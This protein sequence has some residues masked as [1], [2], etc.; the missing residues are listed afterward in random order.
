MVAGEVRDTIYAAAPVP[1]SEWVVRTDQSK[2][3]AL[4]MARRMKRQHRLFL[5]SGFVLSIL[6]GW[7]IA[8]SVSKPIGS[9]SDA[10]Q[11]ISQGDFGELPQTKRGDEI[12]ELNLS[13]NRMVV[14]LQETLARLQAARDFSERIVENIPAGLIVL[15]KGMKVQ[16][17]NQA[18]L[19]I[20]G[21]ESSGDLI[22][23]SIAEMFGS[24]KE[25]MASIQDGLEGGLFPTQERRV[26][27]LD[28]R[29]I[30]AVVTGASLSGPGGE[31]E[32]LL[33]LIQDVTDQRR[34]ERQL[35]QSEKLASVGLISAGISHEL[36]NPLN[37]I[38]WAT[39][40][41]EEELREGNLEGIEG[42]TGSIK[43]AVRRCGVVINTLLDFTRPSPKGKEKVDINNLLDSVVSLTEEPIRTSRIEVWRNYGTIP[44]VEVNLDLMKQVF[45]NLITNAIQAMPDGGVLRVVTGQDQPNRMWIRVSDTGCGIPEKDLK[46]LFTPFFKIREGGT[47][48][49]LW[50]ACSSIQRH[51]GTISVES[52]EG[53]GSTFTVELL[54]GAEGK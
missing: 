51:G 52:R 26:Q 4:D 30:E 45:L 19:Q 20:M 33:L 54:V 38:R 44:E 43:E 23:R 36:K 49:G 5:I 32:G 28:G 48:L 24:E 6:I 9:L 7:G 13:F 29:E 41:V 15:S 1:G 27:I 50:V 47:G 37:T 10:A 46:N 17:T 39:S 35:I 31:I 12:G 16:R 3:E 18:L 25:L 8:Y 42:C 22:G 21:A 40:E 2:E 34:L 53:G 11:R 14:S